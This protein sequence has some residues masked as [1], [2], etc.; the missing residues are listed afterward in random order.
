MTENPYPLWFKSCFGKLFADRG[1]LSKALGKQLRELFD[2]QLI[3]KLRANMKNQLMPIP[4][5]VR[6]SGNYSSLKN[7]F[8]QLDIAA[9]AIRLGGLIAS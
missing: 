4:I 8:E 9:R 1:Y 5:N 7:I 2:L 6:N 3:T